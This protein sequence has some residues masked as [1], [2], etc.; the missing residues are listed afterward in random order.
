VL[1]IARNS[2]CKENGNQETF[3]HQGVIVGPQAGGMAPPG[4]KTMI[5]SPQILM[6]QLYGSPIVSV[7]GPATTTGCTTAKLPNTIPGMASVGIIIFLII[8]LV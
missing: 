2:Y 1:W 6:E 3:F 7:H 8:V 4:Q 5:H